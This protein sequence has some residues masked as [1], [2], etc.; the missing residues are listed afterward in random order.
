M[1]WAQPGCWGFLAP[2]LQSEELVGCQSVT[3]LRPSQLAKAPYCALLSAQPRPAAGRATPRV[4]RAAVRP[5][6]PVRL[7]RGGGPPGLIS[8][9]GVLPCSRARQ[10][11][12]PGSMLDPHDDTDVPSGS[13]DGAQMESTSSPVPRR[14]ASG[15][16]I[17]IQR[18]TDRRDN[19]MK[20]H[21]TQV[22]QDRQHRCKALDMLLQH[23][24]V[25]HTIAITTCCSYSTT[26]SGSHAWQQLHDTRADATMHSP[27]HTDMAAGLLTRFRWRTRDPQSLSDSATKTPT[28]LSPGTPSMPSHGRRRQEH[29]DKAIAAPLCMVLPRLG[30]GSATS[31]WPWRSDRE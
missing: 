20:T 30:G 10:A 9:N 12:A 18:H 24:A 8:P 6:A 22:R 21:K 2:K 4:A 27:A 15:A 25:T 1:V 19:C 26:G 13:T 5:A 16:A 14:Q 3:L 17:A 23:H 29:P 28:A 11:P 31:R 7:G